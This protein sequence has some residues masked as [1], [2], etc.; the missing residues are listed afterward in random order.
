MSS[1]DSKTEPKIPEF[2]KDIAPTSEMIANG[3]F[4]NGSFQTDDSTL[5]LVRAERRRIAIQNKEDRR[6][7]YE[8]L[9][10]ESLSD[11]ATFQDALIRLG[12][13]TVL[14]ALKPNANK[15]DRT[16]M[17]IIAKALKASD[18]VSNRMLG[19]PSRLDD[20]A[21]KQDGLSYLI[22]GQETDGE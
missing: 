8:N 1:N 11:I 21:T 12:K 15:M 10:V 16:D 17:E 5:A 7:E 20:K 9:V 14:E 6:A 22:E 4:G 19:L 2:G 3:K 13:Q 18:Q